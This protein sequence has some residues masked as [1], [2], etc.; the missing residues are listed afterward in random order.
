MKKGDAIRSQV[1]PFGIVPLWFLKRVV[2]DSGAVHLYAWL[3]A[4][5]GR[6]DGPAWPTRER[7]AADLGVSVKWVERKIEVLRKA[8]ALLTERRRRDDGAVLGLEYTLVQVN[9]AEQ[10]PQGDTDVALHGQQQGDTDDAIASVLS[11]THVAPP[12]TLVSLAKRSVDPDLQDP[13]KERSP[14]V[15]KSE[16]ARTLIDDYHD[17]FVARFG[18]K[19][20]IQGGKDG[21]ILKELAEKHGAHRVRELLAL[22]FRTDDPWICNSGYSLGVFAHCFN[23]LQIAQKRTRRATEPDREMQQMHARGAALQAEREHDAQTRIGQ[24]PDHARAVLRRH[25]VAWLESVS[26][27]MCVRMKPEAFEERVTRSQVAYVLELARREQLSVSDVLSKLV[28]E[29]AA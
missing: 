28:Q 11:D 4:R 5:Y 3:D 9:P 21:R 20:H 13:K 22:F 29:S 18:E 7:L 16:R 8:E 23:S 24:L 1:G 14:S 12:A 17:G 25:V 6:R 15:P 26:P 27:G 10:K 2:A 19:P